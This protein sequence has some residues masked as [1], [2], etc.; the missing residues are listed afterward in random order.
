MPSACIVR[1]AFHKSN[2]G[3]IANS[4]RPTWQARQSLLALI[5]AKRGSHCCS[6]CNSPRRSLK[7]RFR[8]GRSMRAMCRRCI[9]VH[10][11]SFF[12]LGLFS[13][14]R[15]AIGMAALTSL[16]APYWLFFSVMNCVLT[17]MA[18]IHIRRAH[19][20]RY[21]SF[22]KRRCVAWMRVP[23]GRCP[24]P[25]TGTRCGRQ[26]AGP[27]LGQHLSSTAGSRSC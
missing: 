10:F 22:T 20:R 11:P 2:Y 8:I 1:N 3:R 17:P 27:R 14:M 15:A 21:W 16:L 7:K 25:S 12:S 13:R 5:M 6:T 18:Y 9:G 23:R 24:S 4:Q 19:G 26:A